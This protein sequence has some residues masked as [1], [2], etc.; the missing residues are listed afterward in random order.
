MNWK[1]LLGHDYK[2]KSIHPIKIMNKDNPNGLPLYFET[3]FLY[4][5]SKCQDVKTKKLP[6][7]WV[8]KEKDD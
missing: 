1:C 2:I 6:G 5:C 3:I 4:L 7:F 8:K